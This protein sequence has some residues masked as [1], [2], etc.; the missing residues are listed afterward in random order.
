MACWESEPENEGKKLRYLFVA[1]CSEHFSE[2]IDNDMED[3]HEIGMAAAKKAGVDAFWVAAS[4]M[5]DEEELENDVSTLH[6]VFP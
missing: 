2:D 3:L 4:C 5:R 6:Y 1:Y